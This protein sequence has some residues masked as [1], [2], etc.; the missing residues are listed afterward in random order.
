MELHGLLTMCGGKTG[1]VHRW[2]GGGVGLYTM[3]GE[4]KFGNL[5]RNI[6]GRSNFTF[7]V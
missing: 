6:I 4:E 2:S 7:C 5:L 3:I 1:A